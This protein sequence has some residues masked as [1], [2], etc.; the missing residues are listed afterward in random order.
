MG[1]Q[2]VL[3]V[4]FGTVREE[5]VTGSIFGK[6]TIEVM[7]MTTLDIGD[8]I[9]WLDL[10]ISRKNEKLHNEIIPWNNSKPENII[11]IQKF[12][13]YYKYFYFIMHILFMIIIYYKVKIKKLIYY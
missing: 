1:S 2:S 13:F 5:E 4:Q 7:S 10:I 11:Y 8:I 12:L 3:V 9:V 6:V